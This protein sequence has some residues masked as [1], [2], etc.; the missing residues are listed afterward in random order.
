MLDKVPQV[1]QRKIDTF[2][3]NVSEEVP[4]K[5]KSMSQMGHFNPSTWESEGEGS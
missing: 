3:K 1:L 2:Q 4:L 5:D